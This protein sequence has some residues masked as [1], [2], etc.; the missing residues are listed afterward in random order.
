MKSR[1]ESKERCS[2]CKFGI[3]EDPSNVAS[4]SLWEPGPKQGFCLFEIACRDAQRQMT[5]FSRLSERKHIRLSPFQGFV[6]LRSP[7]NFV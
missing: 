4:R 6:L 5:P 7:P 1:V 2:G 3:A